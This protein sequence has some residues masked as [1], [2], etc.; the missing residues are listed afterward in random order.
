MA[1]H[2]SEVFFAKQE[3]L[4]MDLYYFLMLSSMLISLFELFVNEPVALGILRTTRVMVEV[5]IFGKLFVFVRHDL[6]WNSKL[7]KCTLCVTDDILSGNK[8]R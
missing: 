7:C 5:P 6:L 4:N 1:Y 8:C 2:S 3:L